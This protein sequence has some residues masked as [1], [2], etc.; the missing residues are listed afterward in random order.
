MNS[1]YSPVA[2]SFVVRT[3]SEIPSHLLQRQPFCL[4]NT[5][6]ILRLPREDVVADDGRVIMAGGV[7]FQTQVDAA[8]LVDVCDPNE[9][10]KPE[11]RGTQRFRCVYDPHIQ[12]GLKE[13]KAG[14]KEFLRERQIQ[15]MIKD[16]EANRF[17]CPHLMWNLRADDTIWIYV[18]EL[19]QLRIF[20]GVATRPDTN[21]RHHA[22]IRLHQRYLRWMAETN[23]EKMGNYHPHR[24]YGLV[25]Y[26]DDFRGEARRF[27]VYNFLGWRMPA[28]T[29]HYIQSK[30]QSPHIHSRLARE[31]MERSGVLGTAN[32]E[33]LSNQLSKYTA[34]MVTFGTLV[35]S[36]RSAFPGLNEE[37]YPKILDYLV[38]Y[39]AEL[40]RVRPNEIAVLS[41]SERQNVR[42]TSVAVQ[43][44][45]WRAYIRLAAWLRD[46]KEENW[47]TRL[48]ALA[49]PYTYAVDGQR[50]TCDLF[51]RDNP[52][53]LQRGVL[54]PGKTGVP[55]AVH[56]RSSSVAAFELLRYLAVCY[57]E[58]Q[59]G[60]RLSDLV[61]NRF[62][63]KT[64]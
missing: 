34:K 60:I 17:E 9:L 12:R 3:D 42:E 39:I 43:A 49:N 47:K 18:R 20:Q 10:Y 14:P 51:S 30:G 6:M 22:I 33:I 45:I 57:P 19:K 32:V 53:W 56:N 64:A 48:Q 25:I 50:Q 62:E 63:E 13:T 54:A 40:S 41:Q 8:F 26:T 44:P 11:L 38:E 55:R 4:S 52:V 46:Q 5:E 36:L 61:H 31:L 1:I 2:T 27:C 24:A 21:H 16:I 59:E 23:S 29:A 15:A 7:E 37:A 28:T 35:D 58:R